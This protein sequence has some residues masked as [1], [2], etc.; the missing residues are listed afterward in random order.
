M[1]VTILN[2]ISLPSPL[3]R[4]RSIIARRR[5]AHPPRAQFRIAGESGE[6]PRLLSLSLLPRSTR[7]RRR[8][9]SGRSLGAQSSKL[10]FGKERARV[11]PRATPLRDTRLCASSAGEQPPRR[12]RFCA[13]EAAASSNRERVCAE[14]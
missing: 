10:I 3:T 9:S 1:N 12:R 7:R 8:R 2:S 6:A 4:T 13:N 14:A 11:D 5:S